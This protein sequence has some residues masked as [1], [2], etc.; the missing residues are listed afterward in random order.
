MQIG[1]LV[2]PF[3]RAMT[4]NSTAGSFSANLATSTRPAASATRMVVDRDRGEDRTTLRISLFGTGSNDQTVSVKV[5][6]WIAG[7]ANNLYV[8]QFI[9]QVQGT[10][11]STLVGVTGEDVIATE[12][13]ADVLSLTAGIA[14]LNQGTSD[15]DT[16]W[17]ECDVSGY[18]L[19][20]V[21]FIVGS[22]TDANGIWSF[23]G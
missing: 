17:L 5:F 3:K 19:I 14:T 18:E 20:E 12:M 16:A 23:A 11:S 13:F 10:L 15:V 9:C 2:N 21:S 22:A 4:T 7:V 8:P 6:G 1:V